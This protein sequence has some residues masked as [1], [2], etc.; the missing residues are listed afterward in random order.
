[1]LVLE[2]AAAIVNPP[3]RSMMVGENMTEK[4]HL[5]QVRDEMPSHIHSKISPLCRIRGAKSAISVRG[6]HDL[7]AYEQKRYHHRCHKQR[8]GLHGDF[9]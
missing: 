4:I 1:M 5:S 7:Q 9:I 8:D 2:S 3:M 6:P